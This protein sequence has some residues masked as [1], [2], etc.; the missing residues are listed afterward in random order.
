[1][2]TLF[3]KALYEASSIPEAIDIY[4]S[5]LKSTGNSKDFIHANKLIEYRDLISANVTTNLWNVFDA[6]YGLISKE[7]PDLKFRIS[8]RRKSFI[9][10]EQ[11][12]LKNLEESRSL[13]LI[14]DMIGTRIILLNG[15]EK[16][17]YH[18]MEDLVNLCIR[19]GYTVCEETSHNTKKEFLMSKSD[20]LGDFYYG[21]TDY[22]GFPKENGYR[23]IHTVFR[24]ECGR[25]FEVQVRN[26]EMHVEAA[27]GT[28]NHNVYKQEKY[29]QLWFDRSKINMH[30]YCQLPTGTVMD[31]IGLEYSLELL[32]R[33]KTF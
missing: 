24:N 12:C 2:T 15:N 33:N 19:N 14:H 3:E 32:Q 29:K 5:D 9:G 10:F 13:D 16:D 26:F 23:S 1:M 25:C 22:I 18:V 28:P 20:I 27:Y 6:F 21:I 11:K 30:G 17:C 8:G 4:S 31:L 7:I